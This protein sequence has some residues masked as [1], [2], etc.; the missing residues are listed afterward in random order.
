MAESSESTNLRCPKCKSRNMTLIEI[1]TWETT[2]EVTNGNFNLEDRIG[3]PGHIERVEA[4]CNGCCHHWKPR[5]ARQI[6]D[7]CNPASTT[8]PETNYGGEP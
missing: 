4:T 8:H 7:I 5:G 2:W 6:D 3:N 1:S